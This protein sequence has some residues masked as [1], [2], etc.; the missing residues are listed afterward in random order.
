MKNEKLDKNLKEKLEARQISPSGSGWD[1]LNARLDREERNLQASRKPLKWIGVAAVFLGGIL[2][3]GL[4]FQEGNVAVK[5]PVVTIP[6]KQNSGKETSI[7]EKTFEVEPME[8][9]KAENISVSV[10][11]NQEKPKTKNPVSPAQNLFKDK[12]TEVA[13]RDHFFA[14]PVDTFR[15]RQ[16]ADKII[17]TVMEK[18]QIATV[19]DA[20]IEKLLKQARTEIELEKQFTQSENHVD[21]HALLESVEQ[22]LKP[23]YKEKL[24]QF[25]E[26]RLIQLA[27]AT[28]VSR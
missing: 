17:Q 23:S 24:F 11:E 8:I 9:S 21:A 14:L 25:V 22:E 28:R 2:I 13:G 16:E 3:G 6:P 4:V 19:T 15:F 27:A 10:E 7:P 18:N 26:D 20:E 12:K 5:N 1:K